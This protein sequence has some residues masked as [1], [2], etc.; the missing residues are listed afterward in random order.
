MPM[1][2]F[3]LSNL[4]WEVGGVSFLFS[5]DTLNG[6]A[7]GR[8]RGFGS[9]SGREENCRVVVVKESGRDAMIEGLSLDSEMQGTNVI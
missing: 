6:R 9:K 1:S 4:G 5:D 3:L 2:R 7:R 8:G